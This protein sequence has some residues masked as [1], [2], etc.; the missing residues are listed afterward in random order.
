MEKL[1]RIV[2]ILMNRDGMSKKDA[3]DLVKET[4]EE[5]LAA[6]PWEMEDIMMDN[7]GLEPDYIFNLLG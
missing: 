1:N 4:R 7:L 3:E 5:I 6:D 2:Y